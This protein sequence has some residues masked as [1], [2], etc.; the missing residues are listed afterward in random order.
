MAQ[1]SSL[2][3]TFKCNSSFA[4]LISCAFAVQ[5]MILPFSRAIFNLT[6]HKFG[7][8]TRHIP[9]S[10]FENGFGFLIFSKF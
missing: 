10:P 9:Q 4:I 5:N 1:I 7:T 8:F 6:A 3:L 2:W